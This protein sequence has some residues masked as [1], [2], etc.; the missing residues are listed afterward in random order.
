MIRR[1]PRSTRT[2]TLFPYTTLFRS[3]HRA[4]IDAYRLAEALHHQLL[5]VIGQ[6][7]EAL[8]VGQYRLAAVAERVAVPHCGQRM[9]HRQILSQW[10]AQHMRIH[11]R[12]AGQ[13]RAKT[14]HAQGQR[15]RKRSEEHTSE[16]QSL[17][18]NSY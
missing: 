8:V 12:R 13:Q 7:A 4:A 9:P 17:M 18:R 1:P 6:E 11:C 2:D 16:L 3:S 10:L 5:K 15:N 14:V